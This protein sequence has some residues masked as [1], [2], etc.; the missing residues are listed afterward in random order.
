MQCVETKQRPGAK[1][2][3]RSAPD[4]IADRAIRFIDGRGGLRRD[5]APAERVWALGRGGA[6]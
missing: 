4:P 1:S 3:C 5:Q 6:R 2:A